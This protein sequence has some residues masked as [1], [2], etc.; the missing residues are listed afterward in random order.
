MLTIPLDAS[1][2][3]KKMGKIR[4]M[5]QLS[6]SRALI[7][8]ECLPDYLAA[9]AIQECAVTPEGEMES[10]EMKDRS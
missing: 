9:S 8:A 5:L 6:V 1:P 10:K 3:T 2:D 4:A 7:G